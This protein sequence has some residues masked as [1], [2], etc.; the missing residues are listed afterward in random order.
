MYSL[1]NI[2]MRFSGNDLFTNISFL[3]NQKDRIGLTGK[4][5]AGKSTLLQI[6]S[7]E[8]EASAGK[9]IIPN[10]KT[11]S[12]LPQH[13]E[14]SS[15]LSIIDEAMTAFEEHK[16]IED[17]IHRITN[18]LANRTDYESKAYNNLI[19]ALQTANDRFNI[20]GGQSRE[21]AAEKVLLGLGFERKDFNN[22][23]NTLSGGWQ[24]RVELAKI[25]LQ[26]PNLLL[27][28]EPTNHLDIESIQWLEDFLK[29]Y[30]GAIIL[31]SHDRA[32]LDA[33][34]NRTIEITKG[35]I[36]DYKCNYSEYITQR[37]GLLEQQ[38]SRY[39]NQQKEIKEI[40]DFIERFRYK[41][42][43]AKQVQSRIKM[44][45]RIDRQEL[46]LMDKKSIHFRFPPAPSSGKISVEIKN[47]AKSYGEKEILKNIE[48]S[49]LRNE[50]IAFV[51]RNGEGKTTLAKS[52]VGRLEHNGE[53][54][55]GHNIKIGYYAQ[56]QA[57][58]LDKEQTVFETI[59]NIAVGEIRKK[60]KSILG[61][62]LFSGEDI[63]KKVKV[64]SGGERS[65]LALAKLLLEPVNLLVLDEPTNHLD[66][67][68]KDILKNA[69]L[70]Y[71]GTLLIVSHDRYFLKDLCQKVYEFRDKGIK[72]HLGDITEFINKKKLQNLSDIEL[73][74]ITNNNTQKQSSSNKEAYLLKKELEKKRRKIAKQIDECETKIED[75]END[76][77]LLDKRLTDPESLGES[78][79]NGSFYSLYNKTKKELDEEV[80]RWEQLH[81][82]AEE[83]G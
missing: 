50:F 18:E 7:N 35:R 1:S 58:L 24:M 79:T 32:F 37:E 77:N 17:E 64:L 57:E 36:Y 15:E 62:F 8:I 3:I 61:S 39:E 54:K 44:L 46:D 38:I 41:A 47:Y 60:V 14:T 20:L 4:N 55:L 70:Q 52:I 82:E 51:G 33:V 30:N 42:S 25:L 73:K 59:D 72:E 45:E 56:N 26:L 23:M 29:S 31:V 68:S 27:L 40:E 49:I 9:V 76:I 74:A 13:M 66:L 16:H 67:Q 11:I 69:L 80:E 83:I 48:I 21:A 65:R 5:G 53:I 43:K 19:D 22:N 81:L 34:T 12:Y 75:L 10:G 2:G 63:D 6:I 71:D 78:L 28:D